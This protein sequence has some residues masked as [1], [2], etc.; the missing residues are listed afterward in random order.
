[1]LDNWLATDFDHRLSK[2]FKTCRLKYH[3]AMHCRQNVRA[4]QGV[5]KTHTGT[6]D[7]YPRPS[8]A[9]EYVMAGWKPASSG[10]ALC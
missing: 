3:N 10:S 4:A 6:M 9:S 7:S 1:M 2:H 5:A 8:A